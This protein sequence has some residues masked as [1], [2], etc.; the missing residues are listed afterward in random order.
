MST[1]DDF[2]ELEGPFEATPGSDSDSTDSSSSF[3]YLD[4]DEYYVTVPWDQST[5]D[6]NGNLTTN[7]SPVNWSLSAQY[8]TI[9]SSG[10]ITF[11]SKGELMY[12][13]ASYNPSA[14]ATVLV[15][16]VEVTTASIDEGKFVVFLEPD[17]G[18]GMVSVYLKKDTK[19]VLIYQKDGVG[20]G[21]ITIELDDCL[22]KL[23]PHDKEKYTHVYATWTVNGVTATPADK[24]LDHS[25]TVLS[26]WTL[27]NFFTPDWNGNWNGKP[28]MVE[29]YPSGQFPGGLYKQ[30]GL[31]RTRG[32]KDGGF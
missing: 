27:T 18:F 12:V 10:I 7:C 30:R 21:D 13:T 1:N 6:A 16:R 20:A 23:T 31:P 32:G 11:G 4:F 9:S 24:Q 25:I 15:H 17:A 2:E 8:A 14:T 28:V 3:C 5:Y 29:I 26:S 22:E 19:Q